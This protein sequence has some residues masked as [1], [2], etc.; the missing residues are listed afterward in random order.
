MNYLPW[1]DEV[2]DKSNRAVAYTKAICER[3]VST[4]FLNEETTRF[5]KNLL[6]IFS[7]DYTSENIMKY[8]W[9]SAVDFNHVKTT[10]RYDTVIDII[11]AV[12]II[13]YMNPDQDIRELYYNAY[14]L[15]TPDEIGVRDRSKFMREVMYYGR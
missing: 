11:H 14:L 13:G 2:F 12:E 9:Y 8:V 5:V 4:K 15:I 7:D 10:E 1:I 6:S 3:L